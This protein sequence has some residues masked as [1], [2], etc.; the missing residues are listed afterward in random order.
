MNEWTRIFRGLPLRIMLLLTLAMLPL[1]Y[2]SVQQTLALSQTAES[3]L[4]LS[5]I[6]MTEA[7]THG[8]KQVLERAFGAAEALASLSRQYGANQDACL[9]VVAGFLQDNPAYSFAAFLDARGKSIC[10]APSG[11]VMPPVARHLLLSTAGNVVAGDDPARAAIIYWPVKEMGG[12]L[13]GWV[14]IAVHAST[15]V[16]TSDLRADAVP[17][18]LTIFGP[19]DAILSTQRS[20]QEPLLAQASMHDGLPAGLLQPLAQDVVNAA[21]EPRLRVTLPLI[22]GQVYAAA[23]WPLP[24][25]VVSLSRGALP[26]T[27]FPGLMW[28]ASLAVAWLAV[29]RLVVRHV[30]RLGQQMR[31]FGQKRT[32][33]QPPNDPSVPPEIRELETT[34]QGMALDLVSEEAR[35]EDALREKNTLIK[36][37]HHRVKNNLQLISSIM[38]LQLRATQTDE[39]KASLIRLQERVRGLATVYSYLYEAEGIERTS[40]SSLLRDVFGQVLNTETLPMVGVSVTESYDDA[41][42][43][44]DQAVPLALLANELAGN[45]LRTVL[46]RPDQQHQ[47]DLSFHVDDSAMARLQCRFSTPRQSCPGGNMGAKGLGGRLI[48][49]F[50]QQLD[51]SVTVDETPEHFHVEV[52]FNLSDKDYEDRTY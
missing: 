43:T 20:A 30:Q 29:H 41:F 40:A 47:I 5:L 36:E 6:A 46:Q 38:S 50:A 44:A 51:A 10:V 45:A 8:E 37:V 25:D 35:M 7:A 23:M 28:L 26:A 9:N 1:G 2:L 27:V 32:I 12:T 52:A 19:D 16:A 18:L 11:T 48:D 4:R 17:L 33:P 39:A 21:G 3:R 49:A 42:L 34:F 31:R 24:Q 15:L 13:I 22:P 14:A